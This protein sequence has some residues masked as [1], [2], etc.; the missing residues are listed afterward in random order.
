MS[1]RVCWVLWVKKSLKYRM[2]CD[3]RMLQT[4]QERAEN[5]LLGCL[6][7]NCFNGFSISLSR[8]VL[9]FVK[10]ESDTWLFA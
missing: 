6:L 5:A 4:S 10:L 1:V 9:K 2:L 3:V 7:A 8:P